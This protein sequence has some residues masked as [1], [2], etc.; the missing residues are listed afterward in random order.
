MTSNFR[1]WVLS[2]ALAF[3]LPG[4]IIVDDDDDDSGVLTVA[5]TIENYNEPSDCAFYGVDR[6]ELAIYDIFN[7]EVTTTYPLC[8]DFAV[9]VVL[10]EGLYSIDVTLVD[11]FNE[12]VTTTT[13]I[14]GVDVEEDEEQVVPINFPTRSFL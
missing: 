9:S 7:D 10:P 6:L 11:S 14:D 12:S 13:S 1:Y 3:T 8:E 5:W 2:A 4:C